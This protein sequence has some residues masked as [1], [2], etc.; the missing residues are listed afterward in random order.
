[1]LYKIYCFLKR[2]FLIQ[3]SYKIPYL[4]GWLR[5]LFTLLPFFFIAKLLGKGVP[6]L[7]E[8]GGDY[9]SFVL[10]GIVTRHFLGQSLSSFSKSFFS[11]QAGGTLEAMLL[12]PTRLP[13]LFV[14]ISLWDFF[15]SLVT[16]TFYLLLGIFLFGVHISWSSLPSACLILL[17]TTVVF[18]SIG[19]LSTSFLLIF[20]RG[21]PFEL[22]FGGLSSLLGGVYFPVSLL[23]SWLQKCSLFLPIT[24]AL[25]A[26][27]RTLLQGVSLNQL[28]PEMMVLGLMAVAFLPL[29]IL[30]FRWALRRAKEDGSLVHY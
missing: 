17:F 18:Y 10:I 2:D 5:N 6:L 29:G 11:E 15:A 22:I 19:I 20:K 24:Y 14:M 7:A 16:V 12:T 27:R 21:D 30:S 25:K 4:L 13:L 26:F 28:G 23:P 3:S 8:S 9:F 1:M